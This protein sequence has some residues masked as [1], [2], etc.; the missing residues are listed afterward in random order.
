LVLATTKPKEIKM[1]VETKSGNR[2]IATA[3]TQTQWDLLQKEASNRNL[4]SCAALMKALLMETLEKPT[5][6]PAAK[7]AAP[8]AE[9]KPEA[10]KAAPAAKATKA[11]ATNSK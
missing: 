10:T 2:T 6:A 7:K 4:R 1:T 8:A 3:V 11:P 9:A 5:K